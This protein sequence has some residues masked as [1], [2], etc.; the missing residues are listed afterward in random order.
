MTVKYLCD[1]CG[2]I[3]SF[4]MSWECGEIAS[5]RMSWGCIIIPL[6]DAKATTVHKTIEVCKIH[7]DKLLTD[8]P[9][10]TDVYN[11]CDALHSAKLSKN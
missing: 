8:P 7:L 11:D 9:S 5:F 4:R 2:E 1:E 6:S 3:A 10:V